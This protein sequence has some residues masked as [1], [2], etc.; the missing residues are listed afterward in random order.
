MTKH[1]HQQE[2]K[3]FLSIKGLTIIVFLLLAIIGI[4]SIKPAPVVSKQYVT[5]TNVVEVVKTNQ[6][7][8][9][10]TNEVVV[11]NNDISNVKVVETFSDRTNLVSVSYKSN[12]NGQ[13]LHTPNT[14]QHK[15]IKI[16]MTKISTLTFTWLGVNYKCVVKKD[17]GFV[18]KDVY[19]KIQRI[20][21]D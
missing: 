14:T 18:D 20:S 9:I 2:K 6:V 15:H 11:S 1:H 12:W 3:S 21:W 4:Q 16:I 10:T 8:V 7:N 5:V 13:Y 19:K 17:I